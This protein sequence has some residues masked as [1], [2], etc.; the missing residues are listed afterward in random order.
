MERRRSKRKVSVNLA[1][2]DHD[3]QLSGVQLARTLNISASGAAVEVTSS[4]RFFIPV[5]KELVLSI[6]LGDESVSVHGRVVH[7]RRKSDRHV[8]VGV[9]FVKLSPDDQKTLLGFLQG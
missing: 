9:R 1:F 3:N 4:D 7:E 8:I 5:G 2:P 6:A